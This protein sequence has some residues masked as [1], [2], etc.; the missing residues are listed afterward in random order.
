LVLFESQS[1]RSLTSEPSQDARRPTRVHTHFA[2]EERWNPYRGKLFL[3]G[4]ELTVTGAPEAM[5][6]CHCTSCRQWSASP[7]NAFTLWKP[8]TVKISKGLDNLVQLQEDGEQHR[9]MVQDL[10]EAMS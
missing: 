4:V 7:L 2:L 8:E 6:Y 3:W 5:G 9:Q 10:A 1:G